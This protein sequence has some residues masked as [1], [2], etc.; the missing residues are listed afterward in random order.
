MKAAGVTTVVNFIASV[1]DLMDAA[2]KQEWT[3][4]WFFTGFGYADLSIL[5]RAYP[6]S[7]SQ[8]MFGLSAIPAITEPEKVT[9]PAVRT[10]RR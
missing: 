9:P 10:R 7:Q 3:P 5:A 1:K 4:E 6:T 8:H 2:D